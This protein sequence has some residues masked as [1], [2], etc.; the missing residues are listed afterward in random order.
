M[1]VQ[2]STT[3]NATVVSLD[4]KVVLCFKLNWSLGD[5]KISLYAG[6][7]LM[8]SRHIYPHT[9]RCSGNEAAI[10]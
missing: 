5:T 8:L 4:D 3:G 7:K 2:N 10:Y 6:H 9:C 1:K